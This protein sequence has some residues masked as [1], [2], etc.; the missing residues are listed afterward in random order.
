MEMV[1]ALATGLA[2]GL[3][4]AAPLGA[5][6]VLLIREGLAVGV[7][8]GAAAAA[9]VA[10]VDAVYCALAVVAGAVVAPIIAS[11]GSI[12]SIVGGVVL[13][14]I[15]VR[16]VH[17]SW[18][19]RE[20]TDAPS[21]AIVPRSR[22]RRFMMFVG[23]TAINPMTLLYFAAVTVAVG[24]AL[25]TVPASAAFIAGVAVASFAWQLG[26]VAVGAVLRTRI[27]ARAQRL[28]SVAGFCLVMALGVVAL[29]SAI[30]S[31]R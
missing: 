20:P 4:L 1:V 25:T 23:L 22:P 9:G 14:V 29:V 11:W 31:G 17:R 24:S 10:I 27:T 8:A 5:I 18:T 30:V 2:A 15:G 28:L 3:G 16:G 7:R 12:P 6:G 19:I 21:G 26:L 13:L